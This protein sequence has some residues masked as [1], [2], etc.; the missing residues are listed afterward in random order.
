MTFGRPSAVKVVPE[1]TGDPGLRA[2]C[3]PSLPEVV[4]PLAQTHLATRYGN[5]N[6]TTRP[7]SLRGLDPSQL[8]R[9]AQ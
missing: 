8:R 3:I 1:A 4:P 9:Q 6:G 7:A 2:C 5:R